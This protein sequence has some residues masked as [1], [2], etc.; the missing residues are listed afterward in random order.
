MDAFITNPCQWRGQLKGK[1]E[2]MA[3][4]KAI[5]VVLVVVY[6][7]LVSALNVKSAEVQKI[8]I[9]TATAE[10]LAQLKGVGPSHAAKIVEYREKNGPFK[11]PE[12]LMQVSG[13]GQ[14]TFEA[15]QEVIL[16]EEPKPKKK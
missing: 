5:F 12:E 9:N 14:K 15:N 11:L 8:N 13:I 1:E 6:I 7:G 4:L 3:N 10:E 16:V 2:K